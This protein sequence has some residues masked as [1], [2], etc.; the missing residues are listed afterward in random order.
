MLVLSMLI[1]ITACGTK[2]EKATGETKP[3]STVSETTTQSQPE[4]KEEAAPI[5]PVNLII[6]GG[7]PAES[8]PDALV[9][10]WNQD[11]P[12]IQVEYVRFTNDDTGNT[13]LDT[14]LLSG[15]QVDLFFTYNTSIL[16]RRIDGEMVEELTNYGVEEFVVNN[17]AG[18]GGGQVL[19]DGIYY[20]LPTAKEPIGFMFNKRMLD[21]AGIT[22]PENWTIEDYAKI[23]EQLT[24]VKEGTTVYGAHSY[25][26]G[27]PLDFALPVLGGDFLYN[28]EG[29][30]SNFDAPEFKANTINRELMEKGF[31][32]P[33]EEVFS[34]N[35][36][37]YAHPAF[38]NEEIAMMPFSAWMLRYVKDLEN[39]PHDF[40]TTFAP[41][42]TIAEGV[43]NPYQ[44]QLNNHLSINSQSK[45]K[46]QAWEF[47]KY[48]ITEGSVF[49]LQGGKM[50][51]WNKANDEETVAG[52]L[53]EDADKLF[54]VEAYKSVMLNP[55]LQYIV[56]TITVAYPQ[57]TQIYREES[58]LFMMGQNDADTYFNNLK[59][60]ADKV[61]Q[62]ELKN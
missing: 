32:M 28:A 51:V 36:Q 44:G 42:P 10:Q 46:E 34:R 31:A 54:D 25:Y 14:A 62:D 26:A 1:S 39:F 8:G 43:P 27:L 57:V 9:A 5:E 50:P 16:K 24:H 3:T 22:I 53:G 59:T 40:V 12:N 18:A 20:A 41:Y 52:I 13:R 19:F 37:A 4:S 61:I 6:W 23:A 56:D 17:V 45:Y 49:M 47:M 30:A 55:E 33:F 29:N 21:E 15:E 2:D 7:V 11:N 35:L 38:L 58:E 60:L 48:W